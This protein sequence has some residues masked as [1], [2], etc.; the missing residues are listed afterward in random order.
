MKYY[1]CPNCNDVTTE[2]EILEECSSGGCGM[3]YCD[4]CNGRILHKY[5]RI[6][7]KE[8]LK[9]RKI[10]LKELLLENLK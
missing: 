5:K 8:Y 3:C 9:I 2:E 6:S 10:S 7:L 4:Y 1:K